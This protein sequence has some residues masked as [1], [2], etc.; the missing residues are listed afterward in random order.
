V[1]EQKKG[2][3]HLKASA[4]T[5]EEVT[6][7]KASV[8]TKLEVVLLKVIQQVRRHINKTYIDINPQQAHQ[9]KKVLSKLGKVFSLRVA[10]KV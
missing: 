1:H 3:A 6:R 9:H 2:V 8:S 5:K 10:I 7:L 4:S